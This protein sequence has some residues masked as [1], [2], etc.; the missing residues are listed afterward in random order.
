MANG[1]AVTARR[2]RLIDA[3]ARERA[4]EQQALKAEAAEQ[5][6][7]AR[8]HA[9]LAEEHEARAEDIEAESSS[10]GEDVSREEA[11]ARRHQEKAGEIEREL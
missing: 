11:A 5:S 8:S 10:A 4:E 7:L 6:E 3:K 2:P 1:S 9:R